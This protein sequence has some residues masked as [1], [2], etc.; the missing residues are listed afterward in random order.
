MERVQGNGPLIECVNPYIQKYI[1]RWDVRQFVRKIRITRNK[2]I[3]ITGTDYFEE[4]I[5]HKPSIEE[6]KE[7]VLAG[8]NKII[9]KEIREDFIWKE[10]PI[11]LSTENQFNYKAAYDLAVQ[12]NGASL[13]MTFKF[14][15]ANNPIYYQFV[16]VEDLADFYVK[17]TSYI[18]TKLA[19][20]WKKKDGIDWSEYEKLLDV[21]IVEDDA[22][23]E[24]EN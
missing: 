20:G 11:W 19:E 2:E 10:M 17:A 16:S 5:N 12:T 9:D 1:I 6:V 24:V 23:T 21:E 7:I 22:E 4:W 14:G 18:N 15:D 13:P 8:M 3:E